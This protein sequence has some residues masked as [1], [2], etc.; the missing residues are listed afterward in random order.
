M[1]AHIYFSEVIYGA[2]TVLGDILSLLENISPDQYI[3]S[4]GEKSSIGHHVRHVYEHFRKILE[5]ISDNSLI[6]YDRRQRKTE[7]ETSH[8]KSL[9]SLETL[10][11]QLDQIPESK[12]LQPVQ[13]EFTCHDNE[14]QFVLLPSTLIREIHFATHHAIH[15][16]LEIQRLCE[17]Q[18][19]IIDED[20]AFA[21]ATVSYLKVGT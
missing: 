12:A 21:P 9:E 19:I 8:F 10:T 18:G 13:V 7:I 2:Q 20:F 5:G 14:G 17:D 4:N 1:Q 11:T 15:H 16:K 3:F 6:S